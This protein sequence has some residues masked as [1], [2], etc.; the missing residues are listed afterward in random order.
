MA[1][2]KPTQTAAPPV[3]IRLLQVIAMGPVSEPLK[4]RQRSIITAI[5]QQTRAEE[6]HGAMANS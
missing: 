4:H 1:V 3:R 2:L 5:V 6:T